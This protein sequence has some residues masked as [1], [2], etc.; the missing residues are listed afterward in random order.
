MFS[1][2]EQSC[3]RNELGDGLLESVLAQRAMS[4]GETEQWEASMF[5][6]LVKTRFEEVP[7]L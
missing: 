7:A 1:T 3:I 2:T 4:E 6:S 5:D